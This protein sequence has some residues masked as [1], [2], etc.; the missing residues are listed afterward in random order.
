MLRIRLAEPR[1]E[2]AVVNLLG[3]LIDFYGDKPEREILRKTFKHVLA[4]HQTI[5]LA[6]AEW[7]GQV[8]GIAGLHAGHY[9][10][11]WDGW[12]GHLEDVYVLPEF[13]RRGIGKALVEFI[14]DTAREMGLIR[15]EMHV[16]TRNTPARTFYTGLGFSSDSVYYSRGRGTEGF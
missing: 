2:E 4:N 7:D 12:Y 5:K 1:D 16:L 13:R 14:V 8:V 3:L 9:S 10:T 6:V 15:L 11:W